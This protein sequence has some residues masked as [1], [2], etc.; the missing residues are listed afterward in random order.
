MR[1]GPRTRTAARLARELRERVDDAERDARDRARER[2]RRIARASSRRSPCASAVLGARE[3]ARDGR[4]ASEMIARRG[5]AAYPSRLEARARAAQSCAS[6][7]SAASNAATTSASVPSAVQSSA[8]DAGAARSPTRP[9]AAARATVR[10]A[11]ARL[12]GSSRPSR[13]HASSAA[14]ASPPRARARR[15]RPSA[16]TRARSDRIHRRLGERADLVRVAHALRDGEE[17]VGDVERLGADERVERARERGRV[18]ATQD[19]RQAPSPCGAGAPLAMRRPALLE[20]AACAPDPRS[21][22]SLSTRWS[23]ARR[24]R[25]RSV[26]CRTGASLLVVRLALAE[27]VEH[28]R[29]ESLARGRRR[30]FVRL[31]G[32]R[33]RREPQQIDERAALEEARVEIAQTA[34]DV[35]RASAPCP[36]SSVT[37]FER[38]DEAVHRSRARPCAVRV[39]GARALGRERRERAAPPERRADRP[40]APPR[41]TCSRARCGMRSRSRTVSRSSGGFAFV[42]ALV[43]A[44]RLHDLADGS[45]E[46][47]GVAEIRADV[48][49]RLR[50]DVRRALG[51]LREQLARDVGLGLGRAREAP[52]ERRRRAEILRERPPSA[53]HCLTS[54]ARPRARPRSS[55][56]STSPRAATRS[57]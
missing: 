54:A 42:A 29:G 48:D 12:D 5:H 39:R 18:G 43:V 8:S 37:R 51:E 7:V 17:R 2:S 3:H 4:R 53:I 47:T 24:R 41:R 15:S 25:R 22:R 57:A 13:V 36:A 44:K 9:G 40:R 49:R 35:R 32:L 34:S 19:R 26:A 28:P 56:R 20:R 1:T 52:H 16:R 21:P 23:S 50:D 10:S 31:R 33:R 11:S 46:R 30:L 55:P 45:L 27:A 14:S 38:V 6:D